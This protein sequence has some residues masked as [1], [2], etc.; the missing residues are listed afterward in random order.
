MTYWGKYY[1][2]SPRCSDRC[3]P[4]GG[5]GLL[6]VF[7]TIPSI[8]HANDQLDWTQREQKRKEKNRTKHTTS[9]SI[10]V[11]IWGNK[12]LLVTDCRPI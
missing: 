3:K 8:P 5:T 6:L 2:L 9:F 4:K 10:S 11:T 1:F 7:H 12:I